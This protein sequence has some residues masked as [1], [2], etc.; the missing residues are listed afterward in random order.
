MK[1]VNSSCLQN[2]WFYIFA[3]F[4]ILFAK[5]VAQ[6]V[7]ANKPWSILDFSTFLTW[8]YFGSILDP[9]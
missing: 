2:I 3:S 4:I 5:L 6:G 7:F 9:F 1:N 8:I